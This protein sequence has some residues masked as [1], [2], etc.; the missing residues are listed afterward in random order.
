MINEKHY[1]IPA[2]TIVIMNIQGSHTNPVHWGSDVL[3]WNPGRWISTTGGKEELISV[4]AGSFIPFASGA[5]ICPGRKFS[6]VEF[7]A[8]MFFLLRSYRVEP[9]LEDG[10]SLPSAASR[11]MAEVDDSSYNFLL[12]MKHPERVKLKLVARKTPDV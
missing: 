10:E 7:V 11:I 2:K 12:K 8:M 3:K 6:Q 5:R 9:M 1:T 4:P